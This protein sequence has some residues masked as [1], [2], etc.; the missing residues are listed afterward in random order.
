MEHLTPHDK[1]KEIILSKSRFKVIRAGRRG[2]K[3]KLEVEDMCFDAVSD[4]NRPIFYIAPT[5]KQ[6]RSIVW[7]ML[8]TR[9]AGIGEANEGRLEM[10]VPTQQG[11]HSMIYVSGWENRENFRGMN[12][13]KIVFDEVDTMKDFFIG[14]QEIFRPAL[15]DLGGKA[16]FIGT[17]KKE[18]PNLRR[19]EKE[20]NDDMDWSAFHFTTEDNPFIPPEEIKK[21]K[22]ELDFETYKQE[23]LAEYIDNQGALFRYTSLVDVFSNTITKEATKYLSVDIADDGSDKTTFSFWE[24]LEEYRVEEYSRLNTETIISKIREFTAE[25]KIP[26]SHTIV[27]GIGVGAGVASSSLLDGIINYKSSYRAI[28]TD[29]DIIRLPDVGYIDDPMIPK[30][31]DF[32]N[33]RSQCVFTLSDLINNHKIASRVDG[34]HKEWIIE[35]LSNYQDVSLGDGK[36]MAT[37][38]EDLKE[39][40]GRS[41]DHSDTWIMRMYFEVVKK[42]L[43]TQS[44]EGS[45]VINTQSNQFKINQSNFEN[46]SNR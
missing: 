4:K 7:E 13:Y 10:K 28:K 43:P 16:V 35:E 21:A 24:G 38:K 11:G 3:T 27:D 23:F 45:K 36:R 22:E 8:K 18:N 31:T 20:G 32:R 14:W 41:P 44:E 9:L 34:R 30:I 37:Q 46:N 40:I 2:G 12:A 5:Q 26:Y 25:D 1:Q 6:A 39:I 19:L 33:L 29:Q 15:I 42:I 17:P